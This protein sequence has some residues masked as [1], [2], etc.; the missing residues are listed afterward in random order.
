MWCGQRH[1][2][3]KNGTVSCREYIAGSYEAPAVFVGGGGGGG[4]VAAALQRV[5]NALR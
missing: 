3:K 4:M 2:L 1:P 5:R